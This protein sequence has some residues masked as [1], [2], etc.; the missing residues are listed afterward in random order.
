[1]SDQGNSQSL[2][3]YTRHHCARQW[4]LFL[5]V[6]FDELL[7]TAG[8]REAMGFWRH[9]GSKM[10]AEMGLGEC[11][12]L[13]QLQRM[14]NLRLEEMDWGYVELRAEDNAI[15]IQ[16]IACP[17]PGSNDVRVEQGLVT[18]S[19]LLEGLYGHWLNQQAGESG[20]PLRSTGHSVPNRTLNFYYG[21]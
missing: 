1:M 16:H 19:A 15:Y 20:V 3:F 11:D 13:E 7:V 21:K 5:E 10:A 4:R 6:L 9:L 14:I 8:E 12:T 17:A 18:M 2:D